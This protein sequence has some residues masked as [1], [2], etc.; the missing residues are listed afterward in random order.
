[1]TT[2]SS[3]QNGGSLSKAFN[4][5]S[6]GSDHKMV[7]AKIKLALRA[8]KIKTASYARCT[9]QTEKFKEVKF[10]N[11]FDLEFRNNFAAL[12]SETTQAEDTRELIQQQA[13]ALNTAL[14]SACEKVLGKRP[15]SKQPRWVSSSTLQLINDEGAAK[16]KYMRTQQKVE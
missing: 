14:V 16:V 1:L 2:S 8:T 3:T 7:S 4:T 12:I 5:C 6:I 10:R 11:E 15:K 13:D 9:F